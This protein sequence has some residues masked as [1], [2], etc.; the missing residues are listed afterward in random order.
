VS[1]AGQ[2]RAWTQVGLICI[3][4]INRKLNPASLVVNHEPDIVS[5]KERDNRPVSLETLPKSW[6]NCPEL[7]LV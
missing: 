7:A 4:G 1:F 2:N 6:L 5:D 3:P